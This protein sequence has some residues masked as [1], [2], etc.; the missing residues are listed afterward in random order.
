MLALGL[1]LLGNKNNVKVYF[2]ISVQSCMYFSLDAL[3]EIQI[4]EVIYFLLAPF[5]HDNSLES[6]T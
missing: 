3:P 1:I 2:L 5:K 6:T 4:L